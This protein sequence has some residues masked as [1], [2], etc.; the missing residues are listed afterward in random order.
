VVLPV[1]RPEPITI[2]SPGFTPEPATAAQM[3]FC[4]FDFTTTFILIH[5]LLPNPNEA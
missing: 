5:F 2:I 4:Q 3:S 1:C